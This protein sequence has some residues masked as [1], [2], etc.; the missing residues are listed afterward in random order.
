M[1]RV[2]DLTT[3]P[4]STMPALWIPFHSNKGKRKSSILT[5]F[6]FFYI[7]FCFSLYLSVLQKFWGFADEEIIA[8]RWYKSVS[9]SSSIR[10]SYVLP[11]LIRLLQWRLSGF[12]IWCQSAD[13]FL[14]FLDDLCRSVQFRFDFVRIVNWIVCEIVTDIRIMHC[15]Y[16]LCTRSLLW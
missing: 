6:A 14:L 13:D 5:T 3:L 8:W 9:S 11:Y 2:E 1:E 4:S 15:S 16:W 12:S 7:F 10:L